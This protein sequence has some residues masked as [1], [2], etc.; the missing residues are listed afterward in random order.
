MNFPGYNQ[1]SKISMRTLCAA[2]LLLF[3]CIASPLALALTP[4]DVCTME[5]CIE[6]GHCCCS[7]HHTYVE[8][9]LPDGRDAFN[10]SVLSTP[11][12]SKCATTMTQSPSAIRHIEFT[13]A[14]FIEFS[15]SALP[16]RRTVFLKTNP[17]ALRESPPRAPPASH[18]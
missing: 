12:P 5:C 10:N 4:V 14:R 9:Q 17:F 7:P 13:Q 6:E 16:I 1:H 15:F 8:G 18:R 11:C 2:L 3:G